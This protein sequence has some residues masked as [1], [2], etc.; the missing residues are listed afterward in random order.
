MEVRVQ[1]NEV[2]VPQL[3]IDQEALVSF[4]SLPDA[5]TTGTVSW[6]A[7]TGT[8]SNGVVTYDVDIELPSRP[9]H[10]KLGMT[11]TADI[12]V[13]EAADVVSV[14]NAAVKS[15]NGKKYVNV[16]KGQR[17][18][19]V[20]VEVG[21]SNDARTVI[22]R[23]LSAGDVV[24]TSTVTAETEQGGMGLLPPMSGGQGGP[25]PGMGS[26]RAP[27]AQGGSPSGGGN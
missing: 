4:D 2:D 22:K 15:D 9:K 10:L 12:I 17:V 24:V 21:L 3:A 14:P 20:D 13:L 26:G 1:V 18:E 16:L 27:G 25:P 6:I 7:P 23:G 8:D 5:S 19:K 11:A